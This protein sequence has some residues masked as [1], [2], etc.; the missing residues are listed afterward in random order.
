MT[1]KILVVN[2]LQNETDHIDSDKEDD[3]RPL[4]KP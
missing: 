3:C 4:G 1:Q 2:T